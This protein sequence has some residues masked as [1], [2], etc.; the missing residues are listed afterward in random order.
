MFKNP[1]AKGGDL[2]TDWVENFTKNNNVENLEENSEAQRLPFTF[3]FY[4]QQLSLTISTPQNSVNLLNELN[5]LLTDVRTVIAVGVQYNHL[6]FNP[7]STLV[8]CQN[9]ALLAIQR[10]EFIAGRTSVRLNLIKPNRNWY[11]TYIIGPTPNVIIDKSHV[12]SNMK[13]NLLSEDI[14]NINISTKDS[15]YKRLKKIYEKY[16]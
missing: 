7:N 5:G 3:Q 13:S 16:Y 11:N 4:F 2:Y 6:D 10:G 1:W 15:N 14:V 9:L 12:L 8:D